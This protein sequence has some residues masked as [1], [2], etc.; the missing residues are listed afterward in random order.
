[1]RNLHRLLPWRRR[2][3]DDK[4][5]VLAGELLREG[6]LFW[7]EFIA[8]HDAPGV[9]RPLAKRHKTRKQV[10]KQRN[11][12]SIRLLLSR[13]FKDRLRTLCQSALDAADRVVVGAGH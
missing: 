4:T 8:S 12:R 6:P 2:C 1:M 5:I 3:S 11:R 10:T 7:A 9:L 13:I